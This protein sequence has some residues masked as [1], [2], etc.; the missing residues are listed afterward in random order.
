[1]KNFNTTEEIEVPKG[2]IDQVIGQDK[3]VDIMKK[4]A[5][6]K[7]NVLLI[8]PPGT[9]KSLLA[10]AMAELLP[11]EE[12]EDILAY[13]NQNNE[14]EPLIRTVKTY[15]DYEFLKKN[16][17]VMKYY[18]QKEL[19]TIK[20]LSLKGEKHKIPEVLKVGLGRRISLQ[21]EQE[22][23][24][25]MINPNLIILF[26]GLILFGIVFLT[27]L[28]ENLK[29]LIVAVLFGLSFLYI[30]S[31]ATMGLSR[32]LS[33]FESTKPKL[34][35]DNTGKTTA[36]FVDATGTR[37]GALLGDVKH[38]PLQCFFPL[39]TTYIFR[40]NILTNKTIEEVV[41]EL[42][43][44]YPE[45]IERDENYEGIVL[46]KEEEIY[47]MGY[48]DGEARFVKILCVNRRKHN[49]KMCMVGEG[50][51]KIVLTPEHKV[52]V[53]GEYVES[54]KI[55]GNE[56]LTKHLK[57]IIS[58]EDIINTF[59]KEDIESAQNY[60]KFIKIKEENPLYGYKRI[61]KILGINS[62]QTRWWNN[63]TYKPRAVRTVEILEKMGLLPFTLENPTLPAVSRILGSTFGDGGIFSTLNAIFLSSSEEDSINQYAQ[64]MISIFG[65]E[66]EG[67][68]ER[69]ISGVNNSGMC[70]WNTN[71]A[72]VRFFIA[73]GAP[74]GRKTKKILEFPAWIYFSQS[75]QQ[76]F[77]GAFLGNEL[78]SPRFCPKQNK[79]Q[80]FGIGIAGEYELKKNRI[81]LLNKIAQYLN[82]YNIRSSAHINE[83]EFRK[84]K[85][86]WRLG[87]STEIENVWRFYNSIPIRYSNAKIERIRKSIADTIERKKEK[88][89]EFAELGKSEAY[90]NATLRV[91][92]ETLQKIILNENLK[93]DNRTIQFSGMVY[94]I[95][96]ESGNLFAN[97][98]LVSNSGGLGT[99][100]HLRIESGAVHRANKGVLFID[101]IASLKLNWQQELLTAM[102]EK[103]YTI[104]GQSENSSG[105]LVKSEPAP[106]DFV[107]VAAG[108]LQD[109]AA[110]HP[111]LRSRIR[112]AGY[113][114]YVEDS[115]EDNEKNIE[116]LIQFVAQEIKKD[117]RIPHFTKD[118]VY[119]V[120]EESKRASGRR[121]KLS[122]NLREL[123]G[124][125]RA[126]GDIAR[127]EKATYVEVKHVEAATKIFN[128]I[129]VQLGK[130]M[131]EQK[132]EYQMI[133]NEGEAIGRVNGLAVLGNSNAGLVLPL[134]AEVTPPASQEEGKVIATGKLG[135]IAKEA[136]ANVSA[137]IKKY[138]GTDIAKKDIHIQFLQT[139]E[140]LEG[141]SASISTALA[142]LSALEEIPVKQ[143][144][145]LTGSL[146]VRGK[147]LP[148]GGINGKLN[149]A[150]DSGIK[151]AIIPESNHQ[152]VYLP[153]GKAEKIK[154][155]PVKDFVEVLEYALK[156]CEKKEKLLK[157]I[158]KKM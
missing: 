65:K 150:I 35:V 145:A 109:L 16:P 157:K 25:K 158:R 51:N 34:I 94:N 6:Q 24:H 88:F 100:A 71:R 20:E 132:K 4:A 32:R 147:V 18:S 28:S 139:Y 92:K 50:D 8:G 61:A 3:A 46:P 135:R 11:K 39:S 38:D 36:P 128:P 96:T 95:T 130:K 133:I 154:I 101:E 148:V 73:L 122:L 84:G 74:V 117:G 66:I 103:K 33:P 5:N 123:G 42:L 146:D 129:E 125:I 27:N 55:V 30:I 9:G 76:E 126:A 13:K 48:K 52:Y 31:N 91:S 141:D 69:R 41:E 114:I 22:D 116:R 70:V 64:D 83:N 140:G 68:F 107:L 21:K 60:Y 72:V 138:I 53:D 54:E 29:W 136:V 81:E 23:N 7:R 115:M 89:S 99:S 113:E 155:Y 127:A 19:M 131:I 151:Y 144:F 153:K 67:N 152:D 121:K 14:N 90:T 118:A 98:I 97:G 63:K 45:R 110:L 26:V 1:M 86:I 59:S 78:C 37:A 56:K 106:T 57:P 137:I 15:P 82:S 80:Y 49:G 87:I 75:A 111:A 105:A 12:L 43:I 112:G 93:S 40:N 156:D 143:S 108:N 104:T 62:G 58:K 10:Q 134:V 2:L 47:T 77:F 124:L 149:A 119:E 44:K 85:F 102:Q 142:V 17:L 120:I 79:I